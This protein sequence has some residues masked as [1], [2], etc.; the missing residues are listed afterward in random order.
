MLQYQALVSLDST[1]P[2]QQFYVEHMVLF[3]RIFRL[4]STRLNSIRLAGPQATPLVRVVHIKLKGQM[5]SG[6][7][8]TSSLITIHD[9]IVWRL[10]QKTS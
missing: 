5:T 10:L 2:M 7:F 3:C 6:Y 4:Y 1:W 9:K 8:E